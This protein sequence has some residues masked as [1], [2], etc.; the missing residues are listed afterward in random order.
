MKKNFLIILLT[1]LAVSCNTKKDIDNVLNV[2]IDQN[3]PKI[4][5]VLI[6]TLFERINKEKLDEI[7][8]KLYDRYDGEDYENVFFTYYLMD[9]EI[10]NG[11]YARAQYNPKESKILGLTESEKIK[12]FSHFNLVGRYW[13]DDMAQLIL[14]IEKEDNKYYIKKYAADFSNDKE[15][16]IRSV[17]DIDT[18]Y[19]I[20]DA[21]DGAYYLIDSNDELS[22]F[23]NQGYINKFLRN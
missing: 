7:S 6:I 9:M 19:K 13:I 17:K 16:L 2:S 5:L 3:N 12:I 1:I 10:G 8:E 22:I 15:L 4:K 23:D 11:S 20:S 18:V 21:E 14:Q